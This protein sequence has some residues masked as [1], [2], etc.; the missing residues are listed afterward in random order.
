[1]PGKGMW[2][3]QNGSRPTTAIL[4]PLGE[5]ARM[6]HNND[7]CSL[8]NTSLVL[9]ALISDPPMEE[10]CSQAT[11]VQIPLLSV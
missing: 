3:V 9:R 10:L 5:A 1:M 8:L 6:V 7:S 2:D 4:R 11:W